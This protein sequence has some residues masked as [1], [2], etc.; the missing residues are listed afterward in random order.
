[1]ALTLTAE[2]GTG[3]ATAN[4]YAT[5]AQGNSYHDG[6]LYATGWTGA[7]TA[8]KEA[9]LVMATRLIDDSFQFEGSKTGDTQALE[10]PRFDIIDR[11]GFLV[12]ATTIPAALVNATAELGRWLLAADRTAETEDLGFKRLKAGSVEMEVDRSD[13][14]ALIPDIVVSMLAP[15]GRLMGGGGTAKVVR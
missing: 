3:S 7:T 10:W 6:H 11:S 8:N 13:R 5:V 12:Q 15:F 14:R 4:S 1:M 9:A 2:T